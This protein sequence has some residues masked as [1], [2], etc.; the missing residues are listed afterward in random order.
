MS[1]SLGLQLNNLYQIVKTLQTTAITNP[2]VAN[3]N[4][5]N[6]SLTNASSISSV[7][8]TLTGTA[9]I[10]T[11]SGNT[12]LVGNLL[13]NGYTLQADSITP[14]KN[15]FTINSPSVYSIPVTQIGTDL[16]STF[17][18]FTTPL[19]NSYSIPPVGTVVTITGS[20][21]VGTNRTY[22][23][24]T[25]ST[26]S[27][28][29]A[30]N[31]AGIPAG[32]YPV[33]ATLTWVAPA[34]TTIAIDSTPV[35]Q[36]TATAI[37]QNQI[38]RLWN[39]GGGISSSLF[40]GDV[41]AGVTSAGTGNTVFG[42]SS[43]NALTSGTSN[44]LIGSE[45]GSVLTSGTANTVVGQYAGRLLQSSNNNTL[46]GAGAGQGLKI[47]TG[48]NVAIGIN[49]ASTLQTG[50]S[51]TH[52]GSSC[53][54]SSSSVINEIVLGSDVTGL[55]SN[56]AVIGSSAVS[57]ISLPPT[58]LLTSGALLTTPPLTSTGAI[59]GT[60]VNGAVL[61][62]GVTTTT[63]GY[64]ASKL[65][66]GNTNIGG[67]A[68]TAITSGNYNTSLGYY[69]GL[70]ITSSSSNTCVGSSAGSA[71]TTG[72]NNIA[73]GYGSGAI[74]GTGSNNMYLGYGSTASGIAV[75]NE[76]VLGQA[77]GIGSNTVI[78]GTS[79]STKVSLPPLVVSN[80]LTSQTGSSLTVQAVAG[81][82]TLLGIKGSATGVGNIPY[83]ASTTSTT[84]AFALQTDTSEHLTYN[85]NTNILKV[86]GVTNGAITVV[87]TA[88][89]LSIAGV[90]ATALSVPNGTANLPLINSSTGTLSLN[91]TTATSTTN[92][93]GTGAS[94]VVIQGNGATALSVNGG[95]TING[96]K[97]TQTAGYSYWQPAGG[98]NGFYI[99]DLSTQLDTPST[100]L[101]R[102][103]G[104]GGTIYQDFYQTMQFRGAT[105]L[106]ESK[107]A[108]VMRITAGSGITVTGSIT[109][110]SL[111][112]NSLIP[113][114][115][116]TL[117]FG[118]SD[119]TSITLNTLAYDNCINF[120]RIISPLGLGAGIS[121]A[122]T[123]NSIKY[124]QF[125]AGFLSSGTGNGNG[126]FFL[127]TLNN[128]VMPSS[129]AV[130][131]ALVYGDWT[132]GLTIAT[133]ITV[134]TVSSYVNARLIL[135]SLEYANG[136]IEY[137][138]TGTKRG[139]I[140]YANSSFP[141][142]IK[143]EG[144]FSLDA[145]TGGNTNISSGGAS[146][147]S[148]INFYTAG[149]VRATFNDTGLQLAQAYQ[150]QLNSSSGSTWTVLAGGTSNNS[151]RISQS[152]G[153]YYELQYLNATG[154]WYSSSDR[155]L[156]KNIELIEDGILDK[157]LQL[158]PSYFH[159]NLQEDETKDKNIGL[160]AQ[161]VV[162][163]FPNDR[164]VK[165][166]DEGN[167]MMDYGNFTVLSIKAIQEQNKLIVNL[168]TQITTQATQ[169]TDLQAQLASLKAVVDAL[170]ASTQTLV[171]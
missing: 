155:N 141:L 104:V 110:G 14:L 60:T 62:G 37:T 108:E 59:N 25:A 136:A 35:L 83:L 55:G 22:T 101:Y 53:I 171:V 34:G 116:T 61:F 32:L 63:L 149:V 140:Q 123:L 64:N 13:A 24:Y 11:I 18:V 84:G 154:V 68:G 148:L 105:T 170:V 54:A 27:V 107:V 57:Q 145:G 20:S 48:S 134:N 165:L 159:Y 103:L 128:N 119:T 113:N 4:F 124:G 79:A 15:V 94:S 43:G 102:M 157:Y 88:S 86:G 117:A 77:T 85:A 112:S 21:V 138:T 67:S 74:I 78:I 125:G 16:A 2:L 80:S 89:Y 127:D 19:T 98:A 90:G 132:S 126:Y 139:V 75:T 71:I 115:G 39:G 135:N 52:I 137:Q 131:S 121:T 73:L 167:Y 156:K 49:T 129:S 26:L 30:G 91:T 82:D 114:T 111:V 160:I 130:S 33:T 58:I 66:T 5:G 9:V 133:P 36:V 162:S 158:K 168:Q 47:G 29:V 76:I 8:L 38:N 153:Y 10:P 3:L 118:K 146:A 169:I 164:I 6:Y 93:G 1:W 72:A 81:Q 28:V 42:K 40:L 51:N 150:I 99:T 163:L 69:A 46:L 17:L 92:I 12:T 166:N 152:G 56:T 100:T 96:I 95:A 31:P 142:Q 50:S 147:G 106:E 122:Y 41:T 65:G 151:F 161:E 7:A 70:A 120:N 87:G 97:S 45:T 23:T 143:S 44:T 109:A 144:G